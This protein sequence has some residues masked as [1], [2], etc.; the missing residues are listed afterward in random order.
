[1][2]RIAE[3]ECR[4]RHQPPRGTNRKRGEVGGDCD[5][6]KHSAQSRKSRF[7]QGGLLAS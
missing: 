7:V 6:Q 4:R 3:V 1:M 2:Y 5:G